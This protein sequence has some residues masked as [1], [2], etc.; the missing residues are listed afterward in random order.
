MVFHIQQSLCAGPVKPILAQG[1]KLG[2]Q[3]LAHGVHMLLAQ[4]LELRHLGAG[5]PFLAD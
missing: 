4:A 5:D 1:G 2:A 3:A